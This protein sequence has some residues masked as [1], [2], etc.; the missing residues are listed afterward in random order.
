MARRGLIGEKRPWWW[1]WNGLVFS[2]LALGLARL[3]KGHRLLYFCVVLFVFLELELE[4]K[5]KKQQT[6]KHNNNNDES[7]SP[8]QQQ[9]QQQQ[10]NPN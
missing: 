7:I 8:K 4:E 3:S 5:D 9:Q 2:V 10:Y 1:K 6:K